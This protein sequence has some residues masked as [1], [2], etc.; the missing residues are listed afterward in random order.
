ME[1]KY[2]DVSSNNLTAIP[3]D[4]FEF[5][6]KIVYLNLSRNDLDEIGTSVLKNLAHLR[7]L[8]LAYNHL[9]SDGFLWPITSLQFLNLSHNNY[10]RINVTILSNLQYAELYDNPWDCQWLVHEMAHTS[11]EGAIAFGRNYIVH[12]RHGVLKVPGI[13]C[14]DLDGTKSLILLDTEK[15]KE[16]ILKV[17]NVIFNSYNFQFNFMIINRKW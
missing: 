5:T 17:R 8:D 10:N 2:L 9:S 4:L 3:D 6:E 12:H 1:L 15:A 14:H 11:S 7:S 13:Q 16:E